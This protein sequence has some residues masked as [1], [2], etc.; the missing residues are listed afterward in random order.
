MPVLSVDSG[1]LIAP[2]R[3]INPA[4]KWQRQVKAELLLQG[5]AA[6]GVD[7]MTLGDADFAFGKD[8][9]L[10][11]AASLKLPYLAANLLDASSNQPIF[12]AY[13][14]KEVNGMKVGI[15]GLVSETLEVPGLK[16]LPPIP[17]A[18]EAVTA[19]KAQGVTLFMALSN[20]PFGVNEKL[21][22]EI[23]ELEIIVA[24][25]T[26]AKLETPMT[27][28][29]AVLLEVGSRGKHVGIFEATRL[30]GVVGWS[31]MG[32]ETTDSARKL[33]LNSRL[34]V[35]NN[36]LRLAQEERERTRLLKQVEFYNKELK[37][38]EAR[39]S[40]N[41]PND[42]GGKNVFVNKHVELA[43]GMPDDPVVASLT[44]KA[45]ER[46]NH[47]E[48]QEA[49]VAPATAGVVSNPALQ[50]A[51][52]TA[53]MGDFVGSQACAGCH[54][55]QYAQWQS[56]PHAHA[57][58]TLEREKRHLDF[59]CYGCHVT[60]HFLPGGPKQ[61]TQVGALKDVGCESCHMAGK[62]HVA[63]PTVAKLPAKTAEATCLSCHTK[64]QTGG[65][66]VY[67]DY[68]KRVVHT[69][70]AAPSAAK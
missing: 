31:N 23:P 33:Q 3:I 38:L 4:E 25:G 45:L 40:A 9:I 46:M 55:S 49:S 22:T 12:P 36:R 19:L 51:D 68:L 1:S 70:F 11:Q 8:F 29:N 39:A 28:G 15:I 50:Q 63:N 43:K 30:P 10:A 69:A 67:A 17:A 42:K 2:G 47:P 27:H 65:R 59:D 53:V 61:P 66:F 6:M 35:L 14:V 26:K 7:A 58:A 64:E 13:T 16:A 20:Q 34:E 56:T 18:Q 44:D 5:A 57:Y 41:T 37:K 52:S 24:G 60:G 54:A 48:L 32:A 62:Q 21:G